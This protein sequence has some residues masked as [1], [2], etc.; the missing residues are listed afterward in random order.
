MH[1]VLVYRAKLHQI[2]SLH[3]SYFNRFTLSREKS[4]KRAAPPSKYDDLASELRRSSVCLCSRALGDCSWKLLRRPMR[5]G[6][7][8]AW[9]LKLQAL[10]TSLKMLCWRISGRLERAKTL[11]ASMVNGDL[12]GANAIVALHHIVDGLHKLREPAADPALRASIRRML[13]WTNASLHQP[14]CSRGEN[15]RRG[16]R[17]SL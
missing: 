12:A 5:V 10:P 16:R 15:F 17:V 2:W 4:G 6:Q 1:K 7:R 8:P 11:L 9:C 3:E 14:R 13:P